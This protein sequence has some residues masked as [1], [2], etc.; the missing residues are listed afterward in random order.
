MPLRLSFHPSAPKYVT[1]MV[2]LNI[3]VKHSA[4]IQCSGGRD[5][6]LG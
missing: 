5:I 1:P 3:V 2:L 4:K 6:F